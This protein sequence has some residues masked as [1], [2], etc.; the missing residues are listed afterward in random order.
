MK[1]NLVSNGIEYSLGGFIDSILNQMNII[2]I[3][4]KFLPDMLNKILDYKV[5]NYK[6]NYDTQFVKLIC[7]LENFSCF[8]P[9]QQARH[10]SIFLQRYVV[11]YNK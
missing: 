9:H 1:L 6:D 5:E 7:D 11:F 2:I 3:Y 4:I 8:Q 10:L